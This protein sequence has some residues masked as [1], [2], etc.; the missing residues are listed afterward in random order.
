M[1]IPLNLIKEDAEHLEFQRSC[2]ECTACCVLP[3]I[4]IG[5]DSDLL[6]GKQGY[7]PCKYLRTH[8]CGT[9]CSIYSQRPQLCKDYRCLWRAGIIQGDERRRPDKLGLMFTLDEVEDK[10]VIEAWELWPRAASDNPG[11]WVID[12]LDKYARLHIRFYGVPAA[13]QYHGP[14]TLELGNQL[15]EATKI[16]PQILARWLMEKIELN[17]LTVNNRKSV[18]LDLESLLRGEFV[19]R[20]YTPK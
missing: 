8:N 12:S 6:E 15:S 19:P 11:R 7:T 4:P 5:E 2:G 1:R 18:E 14:Q 17:D 16:N 9:G 20:H 3:R 13:L 10:G